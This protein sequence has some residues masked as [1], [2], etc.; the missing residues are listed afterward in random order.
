MAIGG[1]TDRAA[2]IEAGTAIVKAGPVLAAAR[3]VQAAIADRKVRRK[4]I[5]TNSSAIVF[6]WII[7]LTLS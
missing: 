3:E 6:I 2:G 4:S 1:V 7:R 5:S